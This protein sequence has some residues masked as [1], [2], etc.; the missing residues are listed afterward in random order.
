MDRFPFMAC[1]VLGTILALLYTRYPMLLWCNRLSLFTSLA[2]CIAIGGLTLSE[3][4]L[5]G[6]FYALF[7]A[8]TASGRLGI[9]CFLYSVIGALFI[10][11]ALWTPL[12]RSFLSRPMLRKLG[13]LSFPIYLV[14][15]PIICSLGSLTYLS[16]YHHGN[17]VASISAIIVTIIAT[18]ALSIPLALFDDKWLILVRRIT[19]F[20]I[21]SR[22]WK[23]RSQVADK[24]LS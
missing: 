2:I 22:F 14:H 4:D 6:K 12:I 15:T 7:S 10:S 17:T 3:H 20:R 24:S 16:M 23:T 13:H 19:P 1:F 18:F 8:D 9:H 5:P 11:A 21:L